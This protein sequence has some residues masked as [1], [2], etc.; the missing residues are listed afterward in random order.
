MN[1][2]EKELAKN[3]NVAAVDLKAELYNKDTDD[4]NA[5]GWMPL[6]DIYKPE[7]REA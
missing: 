1:T 6:S 3:L 5:Y 4:P 7:K 2:R